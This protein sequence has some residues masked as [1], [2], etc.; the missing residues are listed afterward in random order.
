MRF[1][2][3]RSSRKTEGI[4]KRGKDFLFIKPRFNEKAGTSS[5]SGLIFSFF[6]LLLTWHA[7]LGVRHHFQTDLG[8]LLAANLTQAKRATLQLLESF[9]NPVENFLFVGRQA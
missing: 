7:E 9:A 2:K 4:I 8:Y 1:L 6:L 5:G 3:N